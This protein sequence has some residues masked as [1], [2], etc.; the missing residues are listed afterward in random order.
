M[1]PLY[2]SQQLYII[3][4]KSFSLIAYYISHRM[5][6]HSLI[7]KAKRQKTGIF[8]FLQNN[9]MKNM[10]HFIWTI[11]YK[12]CYITH[13]SKLH[14]EHTI[15]Y[16]SYKTSQILYI[17]YNICYIVLIKRIKKTQLLTIFDGALTNNIFF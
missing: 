2:L 10:N 3:S 17:I 13:I 5:Q 8:K 1:D 9:N 6:W 7:R 14:M 12:Q 11:L 16:I 4:H 15:C